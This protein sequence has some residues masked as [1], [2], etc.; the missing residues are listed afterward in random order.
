VRA[1]L[2]IGNSFVAMRLFHQIKLFG[3]TKRFITL[4]IRRE[5]KNVWESR[6][7]LPPTHVETLL[8]QWSRNTTAE[9]DAPQ[10]P[11]TVIVQPCR[12]RVYS[13]EDYERVMMTGCM[14]LIFLTTGIGWCLSQRRFRRM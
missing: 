2:S 5:D 7:P 1:I 3:A 14:V 8:S 10:E 9:K 12:K 4:G 13:T 6:T 11:L